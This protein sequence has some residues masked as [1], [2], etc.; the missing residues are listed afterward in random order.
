MGDSFKPSDRPTQLCLVPLTEAGKSKLGG[1]EYKCINTPLFYYVHAVNAF[2]NET[3]LTLDLCSSNHSNPLFSP[4]TTL[5]FMQNKTL[6]DSYEYRSGIQRFTV[7]FDD[8]DHVK[9]TDLSPPGIVSDM[10]RVNPN[11]VAKPYCIAYLMEFWHASAEHGG[12]TYANM[13]V[14]RQDVCTGKRTYFHRDALF[15]SE[16]YMIP[17]S[18]DEEEGLL[19]FTAYDGIAKSSSFVVLD[20]KTMTELG[21]IALPEKVPFTIHGDWFPGWMPKSKAAINTDQVVMI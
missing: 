3:G 5:G 21:E 4:M 13:A 9:I 10:P 15:P 2:Q 8:M 17:T 7:A 20:A 16:A 11:N 18:D 19:V 1:K 14:Y 6:R 12:D